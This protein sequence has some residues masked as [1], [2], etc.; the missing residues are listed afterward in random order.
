MKINTWVNNR[1]IIIDTATRFSLLMSTA[2][3]QIAMANP[4]LVNLNAGFSGTGVWARVA[5]SFVGT[6]ADSLK[7]AATATTGAG[8][9]NNAGGGLRRIALNS[10]GTVFTAVSFAEI[11]YANITPSAQ[12][13]SDLDAYATSRYG[14]GLV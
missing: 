5:V 9:G 8:A 13:L 12:N 1:A 2:S 11:C 6:V 10:A 3:A 14:A 7:V 4:T